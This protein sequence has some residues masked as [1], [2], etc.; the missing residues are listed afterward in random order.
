MCV[1]VWT[2][3]L[4]NTRPCMTGCVGAMDRTY[5]TWPCSCQYS[6]VRLQNSIVNHFL[7][8]SKLPI[9]WEGASDVGRIAMVLCSHIKQAAD[10]RV[11]ECVYM[12]MCICCEC[13]CTS[14]CSDLYNPYVLLQWGG[15]GRRNLTYHISPS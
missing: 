13:M 7:L 2:S 12:R 8:F 9:G 1:C 15:G 4:T 5:C 10:V 3:P 6:S 14:V 11:Y